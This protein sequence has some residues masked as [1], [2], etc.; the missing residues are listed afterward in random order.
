[1]GTKSRIDITERSFII[2]RMRHK[3]ENKRTSIYHAAMEVVNHEGVEKASMSKIAKAAGVSSSTIY[4]YFDNK[5]D[6]INKLYLLA[7]QELGTALFKGVSDDMSVEV[8]SKTWMNNY[9]YF[10]VDNP[11]KLSFLEQFYNSPSISPE[12][13]AKGQEYFTPLHKLH[14]KGV[15]E[16]LVKDYPLPLLKA[17]IF[18]PIMSLA[19]SHIN[20]EIEIDK[21]LLQK[22]LD[23]TWSAIKK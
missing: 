1:M 6:M 5:A 20:R 10:L 11:L 3:D 4:I 22:A 9:F 14:Q 23:M 13:E 7:K 15:S 8:A 18:E 2:Q 19:R 16:Q 21:E 17:F 12:T